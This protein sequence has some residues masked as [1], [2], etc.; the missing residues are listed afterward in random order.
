MYLQ[1]GRSD[2]PEKECLDQ[3][4]IVRKELGCELSGRFKARTNR[5]I[6][7]LFHSFYPF[8]NTVQQQEK[9][10]KIKLMKIYYTTFF[11]FILS[12]SH[13]QST[14]CSFLSDFLVAS[15]ASFVARRYVIACLYEI[16]MQ[17]NTP[18]PDTPVN[19][20]RSTAHTAL[21]AYISLLTRTTGQERN[22]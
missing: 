4:D 8:I 10:N 3:C 20:Q 2:K 7:L 18:M 14:F 9:H 22:Q 5:H 17:Y 19:Y 16:M 15:S 6:L 13:T 12:L 1:N 11:A 21:S